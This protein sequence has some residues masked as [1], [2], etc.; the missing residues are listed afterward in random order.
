ML[1]RSIAKTRMEE[2]EFADLMITARP[3]CVNN[4]ILGKGKKDI[5]VVDLVEL[6]DE[7]L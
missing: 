6:I 4:L 3:F 1:F 7:L 5:R 2:A